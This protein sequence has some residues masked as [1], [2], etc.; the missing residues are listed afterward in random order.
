MEVYYC[1]LCS[2]NM[3][4][5]IFLLA[6]LFFFLDQKG[7]K[8]PL[9]PLTC[10]QGFTN[11]LSFVDSHYKTQNW[12]LNPKPTHFFNN[13]L[14]M[15]GNQQHDKTGITT[16]KQ[17]EKRII[18]EGE[19]FPASS[20]TQT[21]DAN[22]VDGAQ[23]SHQILQWRPAAE[24]SSP[25]NSQQLSPDMVQQQQVGVEEARVLVQT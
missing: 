17:Q 18:S 22:T 15:T 5:M 23:L 21:P 25:G 7:Q 11:R 8:S 20:R 1:F 13:L 3:Y 2:V 14:D 9:V 24:G 10:N 16:E 19:H 6:P 4:D 12:E